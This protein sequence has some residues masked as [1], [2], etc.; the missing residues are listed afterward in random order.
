M[1]FFTKNQWHGC[2][3]EKGTRAIGMALT[4]GQHSNFSFRLFFVSHSIEKSITDCT[5]LST[6]ENSRP[7]KTAY[8]KNPYLRRRKRRIQENAGAPTSVQN[9]PQ[10]QHRSRQ[11]G[12]LQPH[13]LYR[14]AWKGDESNVLPRLES[15]LSVSGLN[16][17]NWTEWIKHFKRSNQHQLERKAS[18]QLWNLWAFSH[19]CLNY[20]R[21]PFINFFHSKTN[22]SRVSLWFIMVIQQRHR[23]IF[24]SYVV[25]IACKLGKLHICCAFPTYTWMIVWNKPSTWHLNP[26]PP[27]KKLREVV[28]GQAMKKPSS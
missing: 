2:Q 3:C 18:L 1:V 7:Q 26:K 8:S 16:P 28:R 27:L 17:V 22:E 12:K 23:H 24:I 11:R 25:F 14:L 20:S 21:V 15:V 10:V 6:G 9:A 4:N 19:T 13:V 5:N